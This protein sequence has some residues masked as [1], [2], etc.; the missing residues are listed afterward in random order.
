MTERSWWSSY[1]RPALH[2]PELRCVAEKV[3]DAFRKGAPDVD[4]CSRGSVLKMELKFWPTAPASEERAFNL[5]VSPEQRE[6]LEAW[7]Q[8]GG[9]AG[10]LLG[11]GDGRALY[12]GWSDAR[13]ACVLSAERSL[14]FY[15]ERGRRYAW[16]RGPDAPGLGLLG[17]DLS[18][19]ALDAVSTLPDRERQHEVDPR[20]TDA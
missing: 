8:A 18:E 6:W 9:R 13:G 2:R 15:Q 10:L 3:Q 14:A 1:V 19:G 7:W 20:V 16:K 4:M 5:K 11:F 17:K 12:V